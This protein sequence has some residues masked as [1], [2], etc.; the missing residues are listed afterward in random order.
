MYGGLSKTSSSPLRPAFYADLRLEV[1]DLVADPRRPGTVYAATECPFTG[2]L[3][4]TGRGVLRSTDSG[5][6]WSSF[7]DGLD[8]RCIR[9]L[10][11]SPDGRHLFAGAAAQ[12]VHRI[13]LGG[14]R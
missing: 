8:A 6:T 11:L 4:L 2:G 9:T 7:S 5:R 12:G 13:R 1:S 10:A 3:P 14:R